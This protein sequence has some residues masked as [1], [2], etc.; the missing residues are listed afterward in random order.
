MQIEPDVRAGIRFRNLDVCPCCGSKSL[1]IVFKNGADFE[2][3]LG[4]FSV[5][6]CSQCEVDFTTPQP[7][8]EDVRLLYADRS[9]H[10]FDLSMSFV[11]WLRRFN[12]T[13]QLKRLPMQLREGNPVSLDFG[14]GSGFFT[15]SMRAFLPGRVIGS[16]FH[17]APPSII[18]ANRDIE[19]ISD[20]ELDIL[21]GHLDL[22]VCRNVLEHSINPTIFINRLHGLLKP[23]GL[24]LLEVPNRDS[25]WAHLLGQYNFNFY[26]PRHLYHFDISALE[27]QLSGFMVISSWFDHS[28]IL[29]KSLG[30]MFGTKVS[31]FSLTGLV[32]LPLQVCLDVLFG[33]S[34]QLVVVAQR[35]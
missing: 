29:G 19:Y 2:T 7:Y 28:P 3:D 12:N 20:A 10:D 21:F 14:C 26:L 17:E 9:S 35:N 24:L 8:A 5:L 13:R 34:S 1:N 22:I 25:T 27:R 15:Q 4:T 31:G 16:D 6:H 30:N 33:R 32:L 18:S 11:S 23:G